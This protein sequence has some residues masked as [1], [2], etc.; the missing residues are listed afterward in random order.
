MLV[1]SSPSAVFLRPRKL[2]SS[3]SNRCEDPNALS[4][5]RILTS[6]AAFNAATGRANRAWEVGMGGVWLQVIYMSSPDV[7]WDKCGAV[8]DFQSESYPLVNGYNC[9]ELPF[10]ALLFPWNMVIFHG[11]VSLPE[12]IGIGSCLISMLKLS[13][14]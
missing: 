13:C 14:A 5:L 7:A 8:D 3:S 10:I 4:G 6:T 2:W 1:R 9:G 12:G 11:D